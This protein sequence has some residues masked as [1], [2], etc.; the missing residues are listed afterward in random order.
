MKEN[1]SLLPHFIQ[2]RNLV[3]ETFQI[4]AIY[5]AAKLG[6]ADLLGDGPKS[7]D[8]IADETGNNPDAIY[9]LM[10]ALASIGIFRETS[11]R[12]FELTPMAELLQENHP[13]SLRP[14]VLLVGDP[15]WRE[16]WGNIM[17]SIKTGEPAFEYTFKKGFFDYMGEHEDAMELF[18]G[19]L[20]VFSILNCPV[21]AA[22]YPFSD[23]RKVIDIGGG[24]GSLLAHILRQ[25]P[26][27]HGVLFDLPEVVRGPNEID[28]DIAPRCE[29]VGGD[30]FKAVPEGGDI[31][32]L[33]QIIHDWDDELATKILTNCRKAMVDNGRLL[34]VDAVLA[35]GNNQDLNKFTDLHVLLGAKGAKERTEA[36]FQKLF[37]DAGLELTR[38]ISTA[39]VLS[40][41]IVEG[42]KS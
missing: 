35:P 1:N 31:Y 7:A 41:S 13:M 4:Q 33:Q 34:V 6:I 19:Y 18:Q 28:S 16:P 3:Y 17:Y 5:A 20:T 21:I 23:F 15:I 32:I 29:I 37:Q 8:D 39:S 2:L 10:R 27:V 38:I 24:R 11:A 14:L 30:F 40:F 26:S 9:R 42:K 36:E 12:L 25:H 22:S